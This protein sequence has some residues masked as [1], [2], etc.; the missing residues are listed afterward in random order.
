LHV[1]IFVTVI[2][3]LGLSAR[4]LALRSSYIA[5]SIIPLARRLEQVSGLIR[6]IKPLLHYVHRLISGTLFCRR[7]ALR[8]M[9]VRWQETQARS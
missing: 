9:W 5:T 6:R 3:V 4:S 7:T 8:L 2:F 1:Y